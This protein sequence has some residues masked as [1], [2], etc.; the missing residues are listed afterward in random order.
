MSITNCCC[1]GRRELAIKL[2]DAHAEPT[3]TPHH[4]TE[5]TPD[6][7]ASTAPPVETKITEEI[8]FAK[9]PRELW[10]HAKQFLTACRKN[11][12]VLAEYYSGLLGYKHTMPLLRHDNWSIIMEAAGN[13]DT[14]II[15]F[16]SQIDPGTDIFVGTAGHSPLEEAWKYNQFQT[17]AF[18]CDD[19]ELT[20]DDVRHIIHKVFKD[21]CAFGNAKIAID[22]FERFGVKVDAGFL[23]AC[24]EGRLDIVNRLLKKDSRPKINE[25][26][27]GF[28]AAMAGGHVEVAKAIYMT[29]ELNMNGAI[30][31]RDKSGLRG[32]CEKGHSDA[33]I[34]AIDTCYLTG[35]DFED[36]TSEIK[37][38]PEL[39]Y[40][41]TQ[42][43]PKLES[44]LGPAA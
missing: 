27:D 14:E 12:A 9:I 33:I 43:I 31:L 39:A 44:E 10:F 19:R 42:R 28:H 38:H 23:A 4:S 32:A 5:E 15:K 30:R 26:I 20:Y 25:C 22:I 6:T 7:E 34:W 3:I 37:R 18:I 21:A 11:Q 8:A 13:G 24:G 16:F 40:Y 1:E 29:C 17:A 35:D 41:L 36:M 2:A